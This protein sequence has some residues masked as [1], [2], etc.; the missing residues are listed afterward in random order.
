MSHANDQQTENHWPGYVDALTTMLMVLT[1]VMMILGVAV[2]AMSQNVSRVL[3]EAIARAAMIDPPYEEVPVPELADRILDKLRRNPPRPP[4]Q[5][6]TEAI[7]E[8]GQYDPGKGEGGVPL[9]TRITSVEEAAR[10]RDAAPVRTQAAGT[11]IVLEFRARATRLDEQT[12]TS[13]NA[14]LGTSPVFRAA[15]RLEIRA[16]VDRSSG[17]ITDARRV[18][19]YRAMLVRAAAVKAGIAPERIRLLLDEETR[20]DNMDIVRLLPLPGP[21]RAPS[22]QESRPSAQENRAPAPERPAP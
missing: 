7:I 6:G 11:G 1:F 21:P 8:R 18:A 2:F 15:P 22:A 13:L 17:S 14:L 4:V 9:D 20:E 19:Y 5:R 10:P 3:I 16:L 12:E